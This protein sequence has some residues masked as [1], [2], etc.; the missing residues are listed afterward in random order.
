ML[1]ACIANANKR[2]RGKAC[3]TV[4]RVHEGSAVL[5]LV[6]LQS[7]GLAK[8]AGRKIRITHAAVLHKTHLWTKTHSTTTQPIPA[9]QT[10]PRET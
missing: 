7:V 1:W 4:R 3:S 2:V 8:G 5:Q 9:N 10:I 6:Q